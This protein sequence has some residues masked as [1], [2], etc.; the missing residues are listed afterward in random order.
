MIKRVTFSKYPQSSV[1]IKDFK[2]IG[3]KE[4]ASGA[5]RRFVAWKH[6]TREGK[7]KDSTVAPQQGK[8]RSQISARD[9]LLF[10]PHLAKCFMFV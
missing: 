7:A 10:L 6:Y 1:D 5:A 4:E 8:K 3:E 2:K 9:P